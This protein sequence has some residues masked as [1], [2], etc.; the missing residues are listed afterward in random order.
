ML[1]DTGT[2]GFDTSTGFSLTR[3]RRPTCPAEVSGKPV[4]CHESL[5]R[6]LIQTERCRVILWTASGFLLTFSRDVSSGKAKKEAHH[7][8][9]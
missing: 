2:H 3:N 9:I 4:A 5:S 7:P 1:R 8:T 6:P